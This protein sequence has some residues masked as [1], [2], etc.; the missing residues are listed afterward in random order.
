MPT[1]QLSK[2]ALEGYVGQVLPEDKLKERISF[3]G[4]DLES[5]EGDIITVEVF[6]N[7]PDMLSAP[8]FGRALSSFIGIKKG[9]KHYSVKKSGCKVMIDKSVTMRPYSACAIVKNLHFTDERIREAM[10]IQEKLATTHG[11]NRKK[12][13]YGIYPLKAINFPIKYTAKDPKTVTFRPLGFDKPIKASL[14]EELHPKG[15]EYKHIADGW[16]KYPFFIDDKDNVMCMLPYTNSHDTGKIDESTTE[17]FIECTGN[18]FRNVSLALNILV[19]ALADMGG[20]IYSLEMDYAGKTI[21]TPWPLPYPHGNGRVCGED[22]IRDE[23]AHHSC[24]KLPRGYHAP[25]RHRRGHRN[26]LRL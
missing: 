12:S 17:V 20:E 16:K 10:Q 1:I 8:G 14:V 4:T 2:K 9:L 15:K 7:R 24:P 21:V 13:A 11:R 5:I 25:D 19:T 3:L 18:D 6:P 26:R 22:G 23:R